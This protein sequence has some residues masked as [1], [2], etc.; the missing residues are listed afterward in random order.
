M[1]LP[2]KNY[3][4]RAHRAWLRGRGI[5]ATI[6]ERDDQFEQ[7]RGIAMR[8]DKLARIYR[9]GLCLAA[10]F[11]WHPHQVDLSSVLPERGRLS[12]LGGSGLDVQACT[13]AR[14]DSEPTFAWPST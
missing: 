10:R 7:W 9:S 4:L 3:P 14:I 6:P 1:R 12:A 2:G 11:L 8:S 13:P 5:E